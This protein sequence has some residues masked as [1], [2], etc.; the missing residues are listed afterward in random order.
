MYNIIILDMRSS[1]MNINLDPE[2]FSDEY[3]ERQAVL[4][5]LA[6]EQVAIALITLLLEVG[7]ARLDA[8]M[9]ERGEDVDLFDL[10]RQHDEDEGEPVLNADDLQEWRNWDDENYQYDEGMDGD[11]ESALASAGFGTDEDYGYYGHED[12][13]DIWN[14]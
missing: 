3:E 2:A 4:R 14:D 8:E 5:Q 9:A 13:G 7:I 10:V 12:G 6:Q 1:D 11:H